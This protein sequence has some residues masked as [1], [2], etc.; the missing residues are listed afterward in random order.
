MSLA[1]DALWL[2]EKTAVA[3]KQVALGAAA[4]LAGL[5]LLSPSM[6]N[7]LLGLH[8][9]YHGTDPKNVEDIRRLGLLTQY[10]GTG[11][12]KTHK[13][14]IY[15]K[16]LEHGKAEGR[17]E[18]TQTSKGRVHVTPLKGVAKGYAAF[19]EAPFGTSGRQ[20]SAAML[21]GLLTPLGGRGLVTADIPSELR[22]QFEADP[23]ST[24][25]ARHTPG[26]RG[27][28]NIDP[29][30]IVGSAEHH[31]IEQRV[32]QLKNIRDVVAE[33]PGRFATGVAT[34]TGGLGLTGLGLHQI[35][36]GLSKV[37]TVL[38]LTDPH[39]LQ[40][41]SQ[42]TARP[43]VYGHRTRAIET[44]LSRGRVESAQE[45]LRHGTLQSY[46][47]GHT[48]A[49]HVAPQIGTMTE[50]QLDQF[51]DAML[52]DAPDIEAARTVAGD[53][54]TAAMSQFLQKRHNRVR[55]FLRS[56]PEDAAEE[57][58]SKHLSVSKLSPYIFLTKGLVNDPKYGDVGLF[59]QS[60]TATPSPF[61]NFINTEHVVGPRHPAEERA[62]NARTGYVVGPRTRIAELEAAHPDYNYVS[63]EDIPTELKSKVFIP[64]HSVGEIAR[65]WIPNVASGRARLHPR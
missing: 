31:P 20:R 3:P 5:A 15:D 21:A 36:R 10:G 27:P 60:R 64:T 49:T 54:W 32:E 62:L 33:D 53:N 9:V 2:L 40:R 34:T 14:E 4:T 25:M 12:S 51:G 44:V 22:N 61:M 30:Y 29:K 43:D 24:I 65:R 46:E 52:R 18:Y 42:F 45:A 19:Q 1:D 28:V 58:R 23:D 63:E 8:R 41:F 11:T 17:R 26:L 35:V 16:L 6:T 7:R 13:E 39:Q 55:G 57:F 37:A 38:D 47:K 59:L 50:E 56:M 48:A